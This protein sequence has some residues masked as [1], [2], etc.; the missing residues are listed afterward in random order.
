[1]TRRF[2]DQVDDELR[3][4]L[5]PELRGYSSHRDGRLIKLWYA[6]PAVHFEAQ[7]IG[8]RWVP[9]AGPVIEVGLHLEGPSTEANDEVLAVL[10]RARGWRSRLR[11][12]Q[13]G[14]AFGPQSSRWRRVSEVLDLPDADDA[15]L[16]SEVAAR[17]A[18]YVRTL[19]PLLEAGATKP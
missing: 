11:H 2:F 3:G 6:E 17:L 16:A 8:A 1:M 19:K 12:A 18:V 15:D 4:L 9:G 13:V 7:R 10:R 14:P 5:G